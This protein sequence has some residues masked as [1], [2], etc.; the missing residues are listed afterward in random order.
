MDYP[1]TYTLAKLY[2]SDS[3]LG[4]LCYYITCPYYSIRN[5]FLSLKDKFSAYRYLKDLGGQSGAAITKTVDWDALYKTAEKE[6]KAACTN[7]D[8]YVYDEYYTKYLAE[9]FDDLKDVY[10]SESATG[11]QGMG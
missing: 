5:E 9:R 7:N 1:Q 2:T 4:R 3:F 6:G 10:T 11:S 8:L